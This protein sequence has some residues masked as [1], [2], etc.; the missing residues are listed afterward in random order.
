MES[1]INKGGVLI[2]HDFDIA[3]LDGDYCLDDGI[4]YYVIGTVEEFYETIL[5]VERDTNNKLFL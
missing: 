4:Q 2:D 1:V 5:E 3:I